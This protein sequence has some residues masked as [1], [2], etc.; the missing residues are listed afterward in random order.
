MSAGNTGDAAAR[1]PIL[2]K[3]FALD[4]LLEHIARALQE[5]DGANAPPAPE[6]L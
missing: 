3:P 6:L 5:S 4:A 2:H 1:A